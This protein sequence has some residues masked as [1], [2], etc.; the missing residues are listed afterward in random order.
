M[1]RIT[2]LPLSLLAAIAALVS[3]SQ[4][5]VGIISPEEAKKLIENP[6]AKKRPIVLDTRGE[7]SNPQLSW[8]VPPFTSPVA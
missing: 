3:A 4:A 2:K 8:I 1:N 5:E 6:D 7:E